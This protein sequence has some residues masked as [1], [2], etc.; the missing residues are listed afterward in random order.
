[1]LNSESQ[2]DLVTKQECGNLGRRCEFSR[3]PRTDA[4]DLDS[5]LLQPAIEGGARV[6]KDLGAEFDVS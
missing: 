4:L 2:S 6:M 1:M 5:K 3:R